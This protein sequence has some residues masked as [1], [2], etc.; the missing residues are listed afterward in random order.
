MTPTRTAVVLGGSVAGLITAQVFSDL[1]EA[2]CPAT[3]AGHDVAL[4]GVR[5]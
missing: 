2:R 1:Y 5:D 4:P 3:R